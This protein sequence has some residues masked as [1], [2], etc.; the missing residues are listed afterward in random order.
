MAFWDT[1]NYSEQYR[2]LGTSLLCGETGAYS[3]PCGFWV[4]IPLVIN[5]LKDP[6]SHPVTS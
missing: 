2:S 1:Y 4:F 3:Y 5:A 6:P